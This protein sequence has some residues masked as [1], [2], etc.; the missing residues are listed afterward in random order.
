MDREPQMIARINNMPEYA[1]DYK[2]IVAR[3]CDHEL[4]FYGA[5]DDEATAKTAVDEV[6][7]VVFPREEIK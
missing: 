7:G 4:W 2:Y 5:Y 1:N 6:D 3:I